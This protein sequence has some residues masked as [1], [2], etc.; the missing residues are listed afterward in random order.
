MSKISINLCAYGSMDRTYIYIGIN[1]HV[2]GVTD[3]QLSKLSTF[4]RN[5]GGD[6][7]A[8]QLEGHF[9]TATIITVTLCICTL[10]NVN[11]EYALEGRS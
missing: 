8:G 1:V 6:E 4:R 9:V 11:R 3:S 7:R 10:G 2:T 5:L